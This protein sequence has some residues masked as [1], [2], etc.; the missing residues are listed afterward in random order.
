MTILSCHSPFANFDGVMALDL[1]QNF[2]STQHL[3]NDS[4]ES[5]PKNINQ[6]FNTKFQVRDL[7]LKVIQVSCD[8]SA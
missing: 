7:D 2:V 5:G 3:E 8:C 6:N 4:T 1:C